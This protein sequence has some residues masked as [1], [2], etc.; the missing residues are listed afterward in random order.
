MKRCDGSGPGGGGEVCGLR[1]GYIQSEGGGSSERE[2]EA[3]WEERRVCS[4][5][6]RAGEGG[7]DG[8]GLNW[9]GQICLG[10]GGW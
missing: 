5:D 6:L 1:S 10:W 7:R 4:Y 2:V 3:G 9:Y 8:F